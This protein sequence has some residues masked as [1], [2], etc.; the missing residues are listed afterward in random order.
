MKSSLI[1]F[2][3]ILLIFFSGCKSEE[4]KNEPRQIQRKQNVLPPKTEQPQKTIQKQENIDPKVATEIIAV[5]KENIAATEAEDKKRVLST[6][7]KDS[8][9]FRSTTQGMDYVFANFD[10]KFELEQVEV[11]EVNGDEA[12]VYY[13][14]TTQAIRGEGFAPTRASGIH[15]M[16]KENGKWKIFKTDYLTNEPMK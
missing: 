2:S 8:P 15:N 9:Q 16:K 1:I 12:K 4:Q 5:I 10:M 13:V 3:F 6:I 14:Q 7:H 11:I